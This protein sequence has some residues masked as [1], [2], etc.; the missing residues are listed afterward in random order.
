MVES[1]A[2]ILKRSRTFFEI[3]INGEINSQHVV[4]VNLEIK[5]FPN[6]ILQ[7]DFHL[8]KCAKCKGGN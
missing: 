7:L 1:G 4:E 8:L 3:I 6:F 5:M 2:L